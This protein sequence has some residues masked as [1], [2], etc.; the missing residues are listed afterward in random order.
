MS[1]RKEEDNETGKPEKKKRAPK[2][3][4]LEEIATPHLPFLV[5]DF[6]NTR[7][8]L[9][10]IT[11]SLQ[12]GECV[13]YWMSRDQRAHDNH[14]LIYAQGVAVAKG[15]PLKVI[16]N[17]VPKFLQATLRQYDFM[18]KGLEEVEGV[19]RSKNIPFHLLMGDPVENVPEFANSQR[20]MLVV[21]DFS[22]LR[23]GLAWTKSVG[24]GLDALQAPIPLVQVDAHNVVPCWIASP[25]L[26]Y[27]ART[28]RPKIQ[29]KLPDYL[30]DYPE[31][32]SNSQGSLDGC[33]LIDWN[34]ALSR[35]EIDRTVLPV[36]WLQ[37]GERAAF[38]MLQSFID[39][40][41]KDYGSKRN[42]P[43][44]NNLSNLSPYLHYGHISVQKLVIVL[45][46]SKKFP[47]SADGFIEEATVRSELADNFCFYN[48]KYDSIEGCND[49]AR[50]SL[51]IHETDIRPI[52]YTQNELEA[53]YTHDDVWNAAQLQ[54]T[55]IGKMHG[56]LRMYWAKK[57]LE[58]SPS[59]EEA[60]RVAIYLNDKY[61]LDGRDPN[62]YVGCM[63][64]IGGIHDQGWK[65]R[66]IFGK[67]RY[68]NYNGCKNK[69]DISAFIGRYKP[70]GSNAVDVKAARGL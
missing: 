49:W 65:E 45:K 46:R 53:G 42:D 30:K 62:G 12:S 26:E 55:S 69:F 35:L 14:A 2:K 27:A 54:M 37:P 15:V 39:V 11:D 58:W 18:I 57:I 1:K 63:W 50:E 23:V 28:I 40:R 29:N 36:T 7:A 67:I 41:L 70:A 59:P 6:N 33:Q 51:R 60:L 68:M 21:C 31:L 43:N 19:L 48:P 47:G 56:F 22:P 66:P 61:E 24:E 34:D 8:K 52:L 5:T 4:V 10:S 13:I 38:E 17:M 20:A 3:A 9:L 64:S 25:K 16:F 32:L 44:S